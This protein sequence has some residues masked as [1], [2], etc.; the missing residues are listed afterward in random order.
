MAGLLVSV[1][2]A[3]E[4]RS[5]VEGGAT[6]VDVKE[7]DEGPLGRAS[8]ETWRLVRESVPASIP[9]SV[10]LG[11][12][13][14]WPGPAGPLDGIAFRKLGLSD[15]GPHWAD[16]WA[17]VR[18]DEGGEA[19]WVAVAYADWQVAKSPHPD[20]VLEAAIRADDC[21]GVLLDTWDKSRPS[22]ID[23]TPPWARWVARARRAC[24]TVA[25]AGGLDRRAIA[26]LAPLEPDLFAVR[27][28]ACE[29]SDR[30]GLVRADLVARLVREAG[31]GVTGR[32]VWS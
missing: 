11:E 24:R 32:R 16:R 29:R 23:A 28:A 6:I 2:S 12:L 26:R 8:A 7:P 19:R 27:G 20:A 10:A 17:E 14:D 18:R 25:L 31:H 3:E 15:S 4:A 13:R 5:A 9:I 30:R 21:S 1:R 22:P